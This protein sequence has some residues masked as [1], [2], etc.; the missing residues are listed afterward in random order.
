MKYNNDSIEQLLLTR[1]TRWSNLKVCYRS[2]G[3]YI[4][5]KHKTDIQE[6]VNLQ[7]EL[8]NICEALV[9]PRRLLTIP[10]S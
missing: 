5:W 7:S 9:K 6:S 3:I 1:A 10:G 2:H 4:L 8:M